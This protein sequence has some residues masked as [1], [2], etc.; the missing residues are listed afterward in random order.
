MEKV[1]ELK[2]AKN[3]IC[4]IRGNSALMYVSVRRQKSACHAKCVRLE[5]PACFIS[6]F[7]KTLSLLHLLDSSER[8]TRLQPK[9]VSL[10]FSDKTKEFPPN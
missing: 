6:L 10:H 1:D 5:R 4:R 8:F 7:M 2:L 3:F 9:R